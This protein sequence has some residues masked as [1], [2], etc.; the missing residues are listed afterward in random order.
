LALL[1]PATDKEIQRGIDL[2][3]ALREQHQ[4]TAAQSLQQYCLMICNSNE[5][6]Y[7]D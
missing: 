7:I 3:A 1:R 2:M 5:F 4:L 6:M